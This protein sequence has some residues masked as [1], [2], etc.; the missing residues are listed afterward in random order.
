MVLDK[1]ED[2]YVRIV[3]D[4][5]KNN[6]ICIIRLKE[7]KVLV[8]VLCQIIYKRDSIKVDYFNIVYIYLFF[9]EL[10]L[11]IFT[12]LLNNLTHISSFCL[13]VYDLVDFFLSNNHFLYLI[14]WFV[15]VH[16]NFENN[17]FII[18]VI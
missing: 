8:L 12:I 14:L 11:N 7:K 16:L 18:V 15:N 6:R 2:H 4:K 3:I 10:K 13:T 5:E 1:V 17:F 9:S